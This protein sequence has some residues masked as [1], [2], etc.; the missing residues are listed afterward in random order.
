MLGVGPRCPVGWWNQLQWKPL[1]M[2]T[3][4]PGLF[5]NNNRRITLSG[6]YTDFYFLTQFIVTTL[7]MYKKQQNL[8]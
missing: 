1:I 8:F 2:I 5:Y 6:G 7:Y 3:L 4:G